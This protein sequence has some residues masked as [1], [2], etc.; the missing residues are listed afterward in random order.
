MFYVEGTAM[1]SC[2]QEI[3]AVLGKLAHEIRDAVT[4]FVESPD[5]EKIAPSYSRIAKTNFYKLLS[6]T[7]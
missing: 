2:L 4:I 1:P 6:A 5:F 7:I 3:S